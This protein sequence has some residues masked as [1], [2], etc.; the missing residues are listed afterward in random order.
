MKCLQV[1][2]VVC[3]QKKLKKVAIDFDTALSNNQDLTEQ[4]DSLHSS[5]AL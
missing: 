4:I 3:L 2:A 1:E 5:N